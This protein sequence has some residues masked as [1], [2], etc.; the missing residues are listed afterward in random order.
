MKKVI[1]LLVAVMISSV[2]WADGQA[3]FR[4]NRHHNRIDGNDASVAQVGMFNKAYIDQTN[5]KKSLASIEVWGVGND[6]SIK[7][8]GYGNVAGG[9]VHAYT[10]PC[11]GFC[12]YTDQS[13]FPAEGGVCMS[14]ID[15]ACCGDI[16]HHY[17]SFDLAPL[18]P[19]IF[20]TGFDNVASIS[21]DGSFLMAGIIVEGFNNQVKIDQKGVGNMAAMWVGGKDNHAV[22]KQ[23][24]H[25]SFNYASVKLGGNDNETYASQE[26]YGNVSA[27]D[28]SGKWNKAYVEQDGEFNVAYQKVCGHGNTVLA[29]QMGWDNKSVQITGGSGNTS[30]VS[31]FGMKNQATIVQ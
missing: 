27:Q 13:F 30:L 7:Q 6:A 18:V 26:G 8:A 12:A 31:Q 16:P 23:G 1:L 11:S 5:A 15:V 22:I 17:Y 14:S 10:D 9:E 25:S 19:G 24:R 28:V 29:K 21:Q 2:V 4:N 20:A 3:N